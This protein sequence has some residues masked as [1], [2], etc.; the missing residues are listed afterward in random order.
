[1]G[2]GVS[3][4]G[5]LRLGGNAKR[6]PKQTLEPPEQR[7]VA[8]WAELMRAAKDSGMLQAA[9]PEP[10]VV[11]FAWYYDKY[12]VHELGDRARDPQALLDY[13]PKLRMRES[14]ADASRKEKMKKLASDYY[15]RYRM[16]RLE[17]GAESGSTHPRN[18]AA[19]DLPV[20]LK[21]WVHHEVVKCYIYVDRE[22]L[23]KR[24][25]DRLD[26]EG[27]KAPTSVPKARRTNRIVARDAGR[28]ALRANIT[29]ALQTIGW[30]G[31]GFEEAVETEIARAKGAVL[32]PEH[33]SAVELRRAV[34]GDA[35]VE[36]EGLWE[37]QAPPELRP[38]LFELIK[39]A[40]RDGARKAV[41]RGNVVLVAYPLK[42]GGARERRACFYD[43]IRLVREGHREQMRGKFFQFAPS[44]EPPEDL[45]VT[46]VVNEW[47]DDRA[48]RE[49]V[50]AGTVHLVEWVD[51]RAMAR[52]VLKGFSRIGVQASTGPKTAELRQRVL[53]VAGATRKPF[54]LSYGA[55]L[56]AQFGYSF[57]QAVDLSVIKAYLKVEGE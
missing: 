48:A 35:F 51:S 56:V 18:F 9:E 23:I 3:K 29:R 26:E 22:R 50:R 39:A 31:F 14:R 46:H 8:R 2:E 25:Y 40:A 13:Q 52:E 44:S 30:E 49:L 5:R 47:V 37:E 21:K 19:W 36:N 42:Q 43:A 41:D 12:G 28:A 45:Y 4:R 6:A 53:L 57:D 20:E 24:L 7:L 10:G 38:V 11:L 33:S 16:Y 17:A 55:Q 27:F 15:F 54:D 34:E 1:M 32:P